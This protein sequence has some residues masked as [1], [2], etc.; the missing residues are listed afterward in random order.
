M[1]LVMFSVSHKPS[2]Y[3]SPKPISPY[4]THRLKNSTSFTVIDAVKIYESINNDEGVAFAYNELSTAYRR[5]G[6]IKKRKNIRK[7]LE[8][9]RKNNQTE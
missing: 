8:I 3:A 9:S 2:V 7:A 5:Y 6:D 4:K 1:T